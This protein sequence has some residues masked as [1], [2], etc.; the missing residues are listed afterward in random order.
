MKR[1]IYLI[2]PIFL[3]GGFILCASCNGNITDSPPVP[4]PSFAGDD[5]IDVLSGQ[6]YLIDWDEVK[7]PYGFGTANI[8]FYLIEESKTF[9]FKPCSSWMVTYSQVQISHHVKEETI[10]YYRVRAKTTDHDSKDRY[11][12]C[13]N[14][15]ARRVVP[16]APDIKISLSFN[17]V[18]VSEYSEK[19][20]TIRNTGTAV[21]NISSITAPEG[22]TV[23]PST[24]FTISANNSQVVTMKFLP[25]DDKSYSGNIIINS[26]DPDE[27]QV[28]VSV[29][30]KGDY[31]AVDKSTGKTTNK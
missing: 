26:D 31:F 25:N 18:T 13:S 4:V 16:I 22:F 30:G 3:L 24:A 1:T 19:T 11:S 17:N 8:A 23:V 28:I 15:V 20:F 29:S 5:I 6:E 27:P 14:L 10:Y 9:T 7:D 12:A 21:L 2:F